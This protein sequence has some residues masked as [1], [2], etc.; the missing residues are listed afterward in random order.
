MKEFSNYDNIKRNAEQN[1]ITQLPPGAYNCKILATKYTAP[2][3]DGKSGQITIQFDIAEGPFTNF[4]T[5]Q[6]EN[7]SNPDRRWKGRTMIWE[8]KDDGTEKDEWTKNALARWINA[9]EDS[10]PGYTWDWD[11]SKWQGK[12]VGILFGRV[13]ADIGGKKVEY[14]EARFP[15]S[16]DKIRSGDYKVPPSKAKKGYEAGTTNTDDGFVALSKNEAE[17]IPF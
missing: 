1:S 14:T 17:D 13:G 15:I 9:I 11:E 5:N 12:L 3:A 7:N 6:Y 2:T 16:V 10:N 8:P 4:F